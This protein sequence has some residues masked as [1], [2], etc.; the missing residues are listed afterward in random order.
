MAR[1]LVVEYRSAHR[2]FLV[3]LLV[4]EGH[5]LIEAPGG[6]EALPIARRELPD[7]IIT[8]ILMPSMDGY[9]F[10]RYLRVTPG[11]ERTRVIF[12]TANYLEVDATRLAQACS[13]RQVLSK[14]CKPEGLLRAVDTALVAE[15]PEPLR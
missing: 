5:R 6:A 8:D 10:V 1:I 2:D 15:P 4:N 11:I 13:V 3:R 14:P 9:S 7:L 12:W